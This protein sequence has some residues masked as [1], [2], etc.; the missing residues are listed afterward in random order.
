MATTTAVNKD[1]NPVEPG[2]ING[3]FYKRKSKNE[4]SSV[5]VQ[6]ESIDKTLKA[7][8]SSGGKIVT[9]RH[10]LGEW[11]FMDDFAGPEGNVVV[12]WEKPDQK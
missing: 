9:P 8:E 4:Y 12:L 3:G 2:S 10:S 5:I 6:P 7:I 11:G 1:T